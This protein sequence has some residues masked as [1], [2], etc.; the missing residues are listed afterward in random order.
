MR[1]L[2]PYVLIVCGLL[3]ACGGDEAVDVDLDE[4]TPADECALCGQ[5]G[6]AD[7]FGIARESYLAY[8]IV[9][10]A[11]SASLRTLDDDVALDSR[12]A[13]GIVDKRPFEYIE[14][15]DTVSYVGKTA[16]ELLAKYAQANGF[17]PYCGDGGL[18]P[19]LERCDDGNTVSGD[20]CS[21]T[22]EVEA[23]PQ[24]NLDFFR[25]R[26]E[27]IEGKDIGV[28]LVNQQG[29]YLRERTLATL[30]M[31]AEVEALLERADGILANSKANGKVSFDELA[32]MSKSPFYDSLFTKERE[33]LRRAWSYFEISLEP[34]AEVQPNEGTPIETRVPFTTMMERPG[35][36]KVKPIKI[37]SLADVDDQTVARRL[38][39]LPGLNQDQDAS[40]VEWVDVEAGLTDYPGVFTASEIY[41]MKQMKQALIDAAEASSAGDYAVIY[42]NLGKTGVV[43]GTIS[44]ID[45][46]EFNYSHELNLFYD[47]YSTGAPD[48]NIVHDFRFW[49][50][51]LQN[52][53]SAQGV[54]YV[55][56]AGERFNPRSEVGTV[57]M[58][59]W[60][61]TNRVYNRVV[62]FRYTFGYSSDRKYR[63]NKLAM[64]RPMLEDGTPLTFVQSG[65]NTYYRSG[66]SYSYKRFRLKEA[67]TVFNN[68]MRR[69]APALH[70][71]LKDTI[72]PGRYI[73]GD[74]KVD[75]HASNAI[76]IQYG[77]CEEP[78]HLS[79]GL[80]TESCGGRSFSL[81]TSSGLK[82]NQQNGNKYEEIRLTELEKDM[83]D[84][85]IP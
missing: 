42:K 41:A 37:S 72:K 21:A 43:K 30:T 9:K 12:A 75:I 38:Q 64:A 48:L 40:T 5:D 24:V 34:M 63:E 17:V 66:T 3:S 68:N 69:W 57:L 50:Y 2:I 62:K 56:L 81:S 71:S 26:P 74:V 67:A 11:N 51:L 35:P 31:D 61:G 19:L 58:E 55:T 82:L 78:M 59:Q 77:Q 18:E 1:T 60:D 65:Y 52:G 39:Q 20:G 16:F 15:V 45:D 4:S 36:W 85:L 13:Q 6:K 70:S 76:F 73:W 7:A 46:F 27:L 49:Q 23:Q 79:W 54:R 83:S 8:G 80:E 44:K 28:S 84:V 29:F 22:C 25:A 32:L 14:Q 33:A 10:L 53:K 47:S